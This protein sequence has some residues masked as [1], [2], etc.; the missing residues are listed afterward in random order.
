MSAAIKNPVAKVPPHYRNCSVECD[1]PI[2]ATVTGKSQQ[3]QQHR[4]L[5]IQFDLGTLPTWLKGSLIRNG[6]GLRKIG[7]SE[8]SGHPFDGLALLHHWYVDGAHGSVVYKNKFL[9]SDAY[10]K[11]NCVTN[12][13][14]R[15]VLTICC[16]CCCRCGHR[17]ASRR[18]AS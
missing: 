15:F 1:T 2:A 11:V 13:V 16:R 9:R 4:N 17:R 8:Y 10:V 12:C 18:I 5:L 6:P 14:I 3:Q 7:D